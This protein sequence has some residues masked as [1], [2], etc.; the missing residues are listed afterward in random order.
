MT[1]PQTPSAAAPGGTVAPARPGVRL[2]ALCSLFVLAV[3]SVGYALTGQ[4]GAVSG[5]PHAAA[6]AS[7][8]EQMAEFGAMVDK[9]AERMKAE[10]KA[11]G[12]RML[13]RSYLVLKRPAEAVA[14]YRQAQALEP[15]NATVLADLADALAVVNG[16]SLSGEP[17]ALIEQALKLEP[18]HLKA[19]MLAGSEAYARN[20]KAGAIAFWERM[21]AAGPADHPL[22]QQAAGVIQE[23]RQEM[24]GAAGAT[25]PAP[26][27]TG[28]APAA[29]GPAATAAPAV[30]EA[31]AITGTLTL[32]PA[33][34]GQFAPD[35]TVFIFARP[36]DGPRAPLAVLRRQV[37]DLPL[38]FRL[39]DSMAMSPQAR[40]SGASKVVVGARISRSGQPVAQPGDPEVLSSPVAPGATGLLLEVT[41]SNP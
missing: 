3:G 40:L 8:A 2:I 30:A 20:D 9:L 7:E 41:A 6:E 12:L 10:P 23:T 11:E 35:T 28:G 38:E 4:P 25:S 21:V 15:G 36:V 32:S 18:G 29:G 26:G 17:L 27:P 34:K 31:K 1:A 19:L 5:T 39:D 14:A 37:K 24:G 33:L 22:V 16:R 13:G